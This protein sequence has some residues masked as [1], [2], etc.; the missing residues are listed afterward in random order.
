MGRVYHAVIPTVRGLRR[1]PTRNPWGVNL[2][3]T[4]FWGVVWH[5]AGLRCEY[6]D[7]R[8]GGG[9][10]LPHVIAGADFVA[11]RD[12]LRE[13]LYEKEFSTVA[14]WLAEEVLPLFNT[15]NAVALVS[16]YVDLRGATIEELEAG[17]TR[18][19]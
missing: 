9:P 3:G 11:A 4:Q 13:V 16:D 19:R 17:N 2:A 8:I 12:R 6:A 14:G 15:R 18:C 10:M 1:A 5:D 7:A